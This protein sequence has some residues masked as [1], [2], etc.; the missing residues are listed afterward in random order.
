MFHKET[1]LT[2]FIIHAFTVNRLL[3]YYN[4]GLEV[5]G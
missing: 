4:R 3:K 2:I 1:D 5:L